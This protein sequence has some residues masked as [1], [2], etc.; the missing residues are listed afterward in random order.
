MNA[1]SPLAYLNGLFLPAEEAQLAL[2]DAGFVFGATA[3]EFGRTF[4]HRLFRL[5]EHLRRFGHSCQAACIPQPVRIVELATSAEHLVAHNASLVSPEQELALVL[6]ATPG[7]L[8]IYA[9]LPNDGPPTL[10]MHTFPLAFARYRRLF[11]DGARLVTPVT[12]HVPPQCLDPQI[13]QRSRLHWWVAGRQAE[14]MEP[15]AWA[16]LQ[17]LDGF[18]TETA[19]ANFL[20]VQGGTVVT[21][22]RDTILNGVSL[23][24]TEELCRGLGIPITEKPLSLDDVKSAEEALL[25]G[26]AF[27][28]AGVRSINGVSLPWPGP[29]TQ[30]LTAEWS[31]LVGLDYRGQIVT[32][33]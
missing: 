30:R 11:T 10:G 8:G 19:A 28:L 6:F 25:T 22:P 26:T 15:G 27:C 3:T 23:G 20:I 12:R 1:T 33:R 7:P 32:V 14:A 18:V 2:H 29:V 24:V 17:G 9:G 31:R 21:P 13:K 16:L 5:E 4:G